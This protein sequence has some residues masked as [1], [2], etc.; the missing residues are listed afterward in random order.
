MDQQ[1]ILESSCSSR[2]GTLHL[3]F[4]WRTHTLGEEGRINNLNVGYAKS[5][6]NG[7]TW[8]TSRGRS[9]KLPITQVNAEIIHPVS[10]GSNLIN[11]SGMALDSQ[12]R[13]HVVF[14]CD[15][16]N[17]IPQYQHLWLDGNQ[18]RHQIIS[19]RRDAFSLRGGG[20]LQIP[21]SRPDI[22]IDK[23]D[24]AL[25]IFRGDLTA[26]RMA[27]TML[28][29]P[30]YRYHSRNTRLLSEE[31]VGY[32]EPVIDR[33]RWLEDAILTILLQYNQQP[34]ND[35]GHAEFSSAISL[36]DFRFGG[37]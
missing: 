28:M 20:T 17:G 22:F 7:L 27:V 14:Y 26:N 3:T 35:V 1:R 37:I 8:Q 21:I 18:W 12:N 4:V 30:D 36:A 10:P 11:Q 5:A 16:Q 6:D 13:P 19:Q 25:V 23:D 15:D 9:Y 29:A 33:T 34:D 2:D 31:D 24:N 32:S